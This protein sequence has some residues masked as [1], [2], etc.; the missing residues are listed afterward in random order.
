MNEIQ[1]KPIVVKDFFTPEEYASVYRTINH[2]IEA[3]IAA[4]KD[5]YDAPFNKLGNNGFVVYFDDFEEDVLNKLRDGLSEA[6]GNRVQRPGVLFCRYTKDS[7]NSPRLLPHCD[8][9]VKHPSVTTTLELDTTLEWD[10]YVEHEKFN[11][12]KN[13]MLV[14]SGSHN[15]HWRPEAIFG[16]DDYFDIIILQTYMEKDEDIILDNAHFDAMDVR[17]HEFIEQYR[18][19]FG[20]SLDDRGGSK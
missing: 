1:S 18:E 7:G 8:R 19:L 17:G 2:Y 11:L 12:D 16:D 3:N 10:I 4:G 6:V 9:A 5:K 13:E 15:M 14:F 20:N